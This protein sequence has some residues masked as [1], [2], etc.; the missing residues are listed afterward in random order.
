[1]VVNKYAS[2]DWVAHPKRTRKTTHQRRT[3]NAQNAVI[4][5]FMPKHRRYNLME[6]GK[7]V[8]LCESAG[9]AGAT[10]ATWKG[11]GRNSICSVCSGRRRCSSCPGL[12]RGA[13]WY[14]GSRC[15]CSRCPRLR[16]ARGACLLLD[17]S[18]HWWVC[19]H[20]SSGSMSISGMSS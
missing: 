9:V 15:A 13:R 10:G 18:N 20:W 4:P 17:T 7:L 6:V 11:S 5:P 2:L 19:T 3:Y 8:S 14:I 12:V 16:H 1:M